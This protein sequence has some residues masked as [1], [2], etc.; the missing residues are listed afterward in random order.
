[1][2][3]KASANVDEVGIDERLSSRESERNPPVRLQEAANDGVELLV[4]IVSRGNRTQRLEGFLRLS[5][6]PLESMRMMD[7][8]V[9][10]PEIASLAQ[11]VTREAAIIVFHIR[12]P[13]ISD[14]P[15]PTC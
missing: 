14:H 7:E 12:P 2:R 8:A 13:S 10:A 1:M 3:D 9:R 15:Y 11:V 5:Q 4:E 6:D